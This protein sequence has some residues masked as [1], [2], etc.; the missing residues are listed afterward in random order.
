MLGNFSNA[1]LAGNFGI[2]CEKLP[3]K[4]IA[5]SLIVRNNCSLITRGGDGQPQIVGKG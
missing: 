1:I 3:K 5:Q 4:S 2:V